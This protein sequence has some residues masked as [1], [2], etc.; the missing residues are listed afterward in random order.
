MDVRAALLALGLLA[1]SSGFAQP[2]PAKPLR[3]INPYPAGGPADIVAREI[4]AAVTE[5]I[6]QQ[7]IVESKPG[8]GATIGAD[9]VAK[10]APDGYTLLVGGS[11]SLII[12]PAMQ[13]KPPFDGLRD[14]TPIAMAV[15]VPNVLVAHPSLNVKTLQ[16]VIAL[17]KAKPGT[18]AYGSPGNGSIGQLAMELIKQKTGIDLIHVPYKG[19]PPV[20]TDLIGG[21]IQLGLLNLAPALPHIQSGKMRAIAMATRSRNDVL[22]DLPTIDEA[23]LRGY[24]AGTWYGLFGPA[25][26]PTALV[27]RLASTT[28]KALDTAEV[29]ARFKRQGTDVTPLGSADFAAHVAR[30]HAELVPLIRAIGLKTD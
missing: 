11:P 4:A 10:S 21:Q 5:A 14:F 12:S 24:D 19:G 3:F 22:P 23:G 20:V 27:E 17:A 7:V 8:G 2:Y 15:T 26:L 25:K 13:A 30:E 28:L 16:E 1:S 9:F 6:G 18:L 29:K